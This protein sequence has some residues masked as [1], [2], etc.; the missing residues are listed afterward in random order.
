MTEKRELQ[1]AL[2]HDQW[3]H[4]TKYFLEKLGLWEPPEAVL[5]KTY[6]RDIVDDILRWRHQCVTPYADLFE[7][8]KEADRD[9]ADKSI[10]ILLP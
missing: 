6:P 10:A 5:L 8:E 4:W 1:A 9:W 2:E 3:S 7:I